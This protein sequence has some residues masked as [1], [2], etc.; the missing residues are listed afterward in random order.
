MAVSAGMALAEGDW[1]RIPQGAH[2]PDVKAVLSRAKLDEFLRLYKDEPKTVNVLASEHN[3][4]LYVIRAWA[5]QLGLITSTQAAK[6]GPVKVCK[7]CHEPRLLSL[8]SR[9]YRSRDGYNHVCNI[10]LHPKRQYGGAQKHAKARDAKQ[11]A[12]RD[13]AQSAKEETVYTLQASVPDH[14]FAAL[15]TLFAMFPTTPQALS[16]WQR[17]DLVLWVKA[18]GAVALLH[19]TRAGRDGTVT[20]GETTTTVGRGA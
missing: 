15:H 1:L 2:V 9:Q 4:P 20:D 16:A 19:Y 10:C 12:K 5:M 6:I 7:Q 11:S 17:D 14:P 8:Y 13:A 18:V 3:Q